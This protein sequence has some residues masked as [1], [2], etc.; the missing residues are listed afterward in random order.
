MARTN[1]SIMVKVETMK[2]MLS[3]KVG[4]KTI[5]I[6]EL[7]I[8]QLVDHLGHYDYILNQK[9]YSDRGNR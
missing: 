4:M 1:K 2:M 3:K 9:T 6:P 8:S 7:P 5:S